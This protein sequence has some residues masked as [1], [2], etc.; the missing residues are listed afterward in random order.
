M[1]LQQAGTIRLVNFENL[2]TLRQ[3]GDNAFSS[4]EES[5][6]TDFTG[7]L[8]SG[9]LENSNINPVR[10]MVEMITS[11]EFMKRTSG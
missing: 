3:F 9:Y 4:T 5:V 11:P 10:E 6:Q 8:L 2:Q 7:R 1:V